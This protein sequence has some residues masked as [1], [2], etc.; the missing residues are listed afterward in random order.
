M[1]AEPHKVTLVLSSS[2]VWVRL[3][4]PKDGCGPAS[5]CAE[6]GRPIDDAEAQDAGR[7]ERCELCPVD[8]DECWVKSWF[9]NR[10]GAEM[11]GGRDLD[12]TGRTLPVSIDCYWDG[13]TL[14]WQLSNGA[15]R[16]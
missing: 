12:L 6:C 15:V 1:P 13:D 9:D 11:Y 5:H 3:I 16:G 4:C 2:G 8:T 7:P 14:I 10:D